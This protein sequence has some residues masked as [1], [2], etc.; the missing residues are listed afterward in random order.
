MN[1]NTMRGSASRTLS[2]FLITFCAGVAATLAWWYGHTARQMIANSHPLFGW[3]APAEPQ[4]APD[5][6]AL[7]APVTPSFDQQQLSTMSLDLDAV[8]QSIDRIAAGQE[9]ITRSIDQIATT[10]A[11]GQEQIT[12]SINQ[13]ATSREQTTRSTGQTPAIVATGKEQMTPSID[14]TATNIGHDP[15][16]TASG[17]TVESR[18][19][20]SS[21]PTVRLNTKPTETRP[22][23]TLSEREKQFSAASGH[24]S[25]C[26]PSASAVLQNHPGGRPSWTVRAPG[27]EG[28]KCWYAATRSRASEPSQ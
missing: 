28:T 1:M 25:S 11:G 7:A 19:G 12:R 21:Q 23:Q 8:Q 26:F 20:S 6:I 5:V 14:Q 17:I 4:N 16:A 15:S 13:I 24:D 3:L 2:R 18:D 22:P 9:Q 10:I 27:H